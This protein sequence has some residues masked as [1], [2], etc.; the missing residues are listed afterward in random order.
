MPNTKPYNLTFT[1]YYNFLKYGSYIAVKPTKKYYQDYFR[2][3][4]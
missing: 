3:Y 1:D 2:N 4:Q